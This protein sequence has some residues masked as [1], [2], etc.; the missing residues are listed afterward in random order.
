MLSVLSVSKPPRAQKKVDYTLARETDGFS[1]PKYSPLHPHCDLCVPM[2]HAH[3]RITFCFSSSQERWVCFHLS[4]QIPKGD[5]QKGSVGRDNILTVCNNKKNYRSHR[6]RSKEPPCFPCTIT[7]EREWMTN[8]AA[9]G[10]MQNRQCTASFH[11]DHQVLKSMHAV[12]ISVPGFPE[13]FAST[14]K[15]SWTFADVSVKGNNLTLNY[16]CYDHICTS[17]HSGKSN[18]PASIAKW[19]IN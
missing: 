13:F 14:D 16:L 17:R 3:V 6:Q 2:G 19:V 9:A 15:D 10:C 8:Q 11:W 12:A 5:R 1:P 7:D 18:P 4:S